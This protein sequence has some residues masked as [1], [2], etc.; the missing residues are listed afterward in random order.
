MTHFEG[1]GEILVSSAAD[2]RARRAAKRLETP[3]I[4][5]TEA[6]VK[7]GFGLVSYAL[8]EQVDLDTSSLLFEMPNRNLGR[9][10]LDF[11]KSNPTVFSAGLFQDMD[12]DRFARMAAPLLVEASQYVDIVEVAPR[13]GVHPSTFTAWSLL[14][15]SE[16]LEASKAGRK[17]FL[18]DG[19][20]DGRMQ[21]GAVL[22]E[23]PVT[24][25]D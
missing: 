6:C 20:E 17:V 13:F 14:T 12:S 3:V 11:G 8:T 7:L 9:I 22:V 1:Y 23:E 4:K 16:W 21:L 15:G 2:V 24:D 18:D 25:S 5:L 10:A 19:H